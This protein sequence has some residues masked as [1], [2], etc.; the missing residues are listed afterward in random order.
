VNTEIQKGKGIE[1]LAGTSMAE[2]ARDIEASHGLSGLFERY[3]QIIDE[4]STVAEDLTK[5]ISDILTPNQINAFL[6]QT[7]LCE[8][9]PNYSNSTGLFISQLI[10]NSYDSGSNNFTLDSTELREIVDLGF[11]NQGTPDRPI[12]I[13]ITGNTGGKCGFHSKNAIFNITGNTKGSCG[14]YAENSMFNITGNAEDYI[15]YESRNSEFTISG[16]TGNNCGAWSK[17]STVTITGNIGDGC[18]YESESTYKT[19][20]QETLTKMLEDVPQ[21]N[22]II[23]IQ[24]VKEEIKQDY[25]D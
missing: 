10:Q 9:R 25:A 5:S 3:V 2:E 15:G 16:N 18:G 22:R 17:Y 4:T 24:D 12:E 11:K 23:F 8:N 21:G 20:N 19:S 6:Q 1:N 7:I 13:T 14:G